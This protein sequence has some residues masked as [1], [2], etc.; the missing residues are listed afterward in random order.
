MS[1]LYIVLLVMIIISHGASGQSRNATWCFG[2][3][4]GI[5]FTTSGV[6]PF[7][8]VIQSQEA[9][10]SISDPN[11]NLLFYSG[12]IGGNGIHFASV[13]NN[14]N[15]LLLNGDS[16]ISAASVTQGL[17]ILPFPTDTNMYFLISIGFIPNISTGLSLYSADV[18]INNGTGLVSNKN[19]VI[20][21][22]VAY[23][24]KMIAVKHGNGRD[25]WIINH[26]NNSDQFVINLI[27]NDSISL[28]LSQNIG[29]VLAGLGWGQMTINPS[30][31]KI[32]VVDYSGLLEVFDFNRCSGNLTNYINMS[33]F[34]L[35]GF[36]RYYGAS[37][38]PENI[39]YYST[40]D[41]L[42]QIDLNSANP[43]QTKQLV[44]ADPNGNVCMGQHQLGPNGKIYIANAMP[45]GYP[46]TITD[47]LNTHLTVIDQ[48]DSVGS[49]CNV[50]PYF[51]L[52]GG[53]R[54]YLG[55]PNMP[56]YDLGSLTGSPCDTLTSIHSE[57]YFEPRIEIFPN[58]VTDHFKINSSI[59]TNADLFIEIKIFNS[60]GKLVLEDKM[61]KIGDEINFN[62]YAAGLH[63]IT[64][65]RNGRQWFSKFIKL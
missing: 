8:T 38:S 15:Q 5:I 34:P 11:G 21:S 29:S 49:A 44:Y 25:W 64:L 47:S 9:S 53:A 18:D 42:W 7:T 30:G 50:L 16:I 48:P 58:P 20:D 17:I 32:V 6:L 35:P 41:S 43:I 4:A 39:L 10:A 12:S 45:C 55:L 57:L 62:E 24:E 3:S 28:T 14:L 40:L 51:Q 1:R 63:A 60:N 59:I 52:I 33:D 36:D 56:N 61:H 23:S 27:Q 19:K 65:S 2:D 31:N 46:S 13:Y 37:I 22:T 26:L 54:S